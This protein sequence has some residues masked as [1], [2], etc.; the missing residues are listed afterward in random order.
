MVDFI[1]VQL[2]EQHYL[3]TDI[4]FILNCV[5]VIF[6]VNCD[7]NLAVLRE[8]HILLFIQSMI[9]TGSQS[10]RNTTVC[11]AYDKSRNLSIF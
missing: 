3:S 7:K 8:L 1:V 9:Y 10:I 5:N 6:I 2:C 4:N 11:H